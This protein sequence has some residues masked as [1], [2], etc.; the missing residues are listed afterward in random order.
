MPFE[1]V[2]TPFVLSMRVLPHSQDSGGFFVAVLEKKDWLPWQSK[3][4]AYAVKVAS[5]LPH[6]VDHLPETEH[7]AG[8]S[9]LLGGD[10][11][12][13]PANIKAIDGTLERNDCDV[14][15]EAMA[16]DEGNSNPS[17]DEVKKESSNLGSSSIVPERE[18]PTAAVLGRHVII[19]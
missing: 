10:S 19:M 15:Q 18:R 6:S 17:T 9:D 14:T 8:D 4:K 3:M 1:D 12:S 13:S 16:I 2:S 7:S 11:G 5:N